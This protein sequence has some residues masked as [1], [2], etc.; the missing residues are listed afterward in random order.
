MI[1]DKENIEKAKAKVLKLQK[2]LKAMEKKGSQS[3]DNEDNDEIEEEDD[4]L[5]GDL[6]FSSTVSFHFHTH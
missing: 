4:E 2:Q 6:R 3:T 5:L 1:L